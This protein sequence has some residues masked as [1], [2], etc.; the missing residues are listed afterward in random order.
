MMG[1]LR[2]E[3]IEIDCTMVFSMKPFEG[4]F[5]SETRLREQQ[6]VSYRYEY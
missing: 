1:W 6:K 3:M 2:E 4:V 5:G